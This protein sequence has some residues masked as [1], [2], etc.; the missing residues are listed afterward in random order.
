MTTSDIV[1]FLRKSKQLLSTDIVKDN[2]IE[3]IS[4][5]SRKVDKNYKNEERIRS[6]I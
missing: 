4:D 3:G 6:T 5:D 1:D 2:I